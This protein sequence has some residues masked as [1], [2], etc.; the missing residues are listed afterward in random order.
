M[1]GILVVDD[2]PRIVDIIEKF[3]VIEGFEVNKA[4]DAATALEMI[5]RGG[6]PELIILDARMP[7][8][9]GEEFV[10][11]IR[12]TPKRIPV[13]VLTGSVNIPPS[14]KGGVYEN[15]LYKPVKLADLLKEVQ[16]LLGVKTPDTSGGTEKKYQ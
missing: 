2:D 3:L 5:D 9:S 1:K 10:L 15:L 7:G 11:E 6:M 14:G 13:I 12:K 16:R 8:M 4:F